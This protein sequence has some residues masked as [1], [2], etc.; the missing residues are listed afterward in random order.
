MSEILILKPEIKVRQPDY[1]RLL[2]YPENHELTG[3]PYN[4]AVW[5]EKWYRENCIPW[6]YIRR[7][8]YF[9]TEKNIVNIEGHTFSSAYLRK[10]LI[11]NE[12]DEI[13][14]AAV[15][16][17]AECD[18]M[19]KKLKLEGRDDRLFFLDAYVSAAAEYL[20]EAAALY[21]HELAENRKAVLPHY[22]PGYSG[23]KMEEQ[24]ILWQLINKNHVLKDKL[25]LP[26]SGMLKPLKSMLAVFAVTGCT[27]K[28]NNKL[29]V[30]A[31]C[32][33]PGCRYRRKL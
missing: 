29:I 13:Y 30:C 26:D 17:G 20:L 7:A 24:K 14:L 23:W 32:F 21:I 8:E 11:D 10:K 6:F 28:I 12:A 4:L 1:L 18:E 31:E 2:G 22:S 33:F 3:E 27:D 19:I 15:S 9:N 5:A 16:A 25:Q